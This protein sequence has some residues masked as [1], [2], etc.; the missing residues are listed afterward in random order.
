MIGTLFVD[1]LVSMRILEEWCNL[2]S[3]YFLALDSLE[4]FQADAKLCS[5][6]CNAIKFTCK[7]S[8][9]PL[10]RAL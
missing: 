10:A 6:L 2:R 4:R 3:L 9:L 8:F 1:V 7:H 5:L